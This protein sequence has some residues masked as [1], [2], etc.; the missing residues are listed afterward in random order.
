MKSKTFDFL[1]KLIYRRRKNV[2]PKTQQKKKKKKKNVD[3][4]FFNGENAIPRYTVTADFKIESR[5]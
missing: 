4:K 3:A 1:R 2:H 5:K